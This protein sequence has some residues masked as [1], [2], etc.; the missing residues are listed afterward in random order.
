MSFLTFM[1]HFFS[2]INN[3]G[4]AKCNIT[5]TISAKKVFTIKNPQDSVLTDYI[6]FIVKYMSMIFGKRKILSEFKNNKNCTLFDVL[7]P[8]GEA[9]AIVIL[10]NN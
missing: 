6:R 2:Y 3:I 9:F 1:I 5:T 7:T 4:D 8:S 10:E